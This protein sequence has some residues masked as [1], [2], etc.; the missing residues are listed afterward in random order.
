MSSAVDRLV[1]KALVE[2]RRAEDNRRAVA[3]IA[4]DEGRQVVADTMAEYRN[5]RTVHRI[6]LKPE[7]RVL[8][9]G[10][11]RPAGSVSTHNASIEMMLN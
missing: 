3:L 7:E 5:A 11:Q 10:L 2:S 8:L 9:R 4:T 6:A 1:K